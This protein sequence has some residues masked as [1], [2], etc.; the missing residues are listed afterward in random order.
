MTERTL[1]SRRERRKEETRQRL[2]DAALALMQEKPFDQITVEEITERADV[3][4][5][6]FFSHFP[7]KEHLLIAYTQEMVEEVYEFIEQLQPEK[8]TSQWEVMRQVM[9]FIAER[10][11]QSLERTRS[12]MVACCQSAPL[13]EMMAQMI[14]E[15][16]QH[17][18]QGFAR[19]QAL[20]EYRTDVSAEQLAHYAVRLYRICLMEWMM[21]RPDR[22]LAELVDQTLEFFKPAFM[23]Q[24]DSK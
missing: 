21:E 1:N 12:M 17:A 14:E 2:F 13:R 19:G 5:G 6:T 9:H 20:G 15:A 16:T 8:A 4:K 7:T 24:E 10:D 23:K 11:G 22:P 18:M 3:A